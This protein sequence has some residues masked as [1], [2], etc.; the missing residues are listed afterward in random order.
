MSDTHGLHLQ[1]NFVVPEGDILIFAGDAGIDTKHDAEEF[2]Q[3]LASLPHPHKIVIYGNMDRYG[4][5]DGK[6]TCKLLKNGHVLCNSSVEVAGYRVFGSPYTPKFYGA[7][8]LD[9]PDVA[10]A[11]WSRALPPDSRVDIIVTHSPPHQY[12]DSARGRHVGDAALL[13]AVQSLLQPPKLWVVGHIHESHG[14]YSVP[15]PPSGRSITLVN[16]ALD[17]MKRKVPGIAPRVVELPAGTVQPLEGEDTG[18]HD[19]HSKGGGGVMSWLS[20]ML[21]V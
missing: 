20:N 3:W 2:D 18:G 15:H 13:E 7:Y 6:G 12:G 9:N 4:E 16:V 10:R 21:R 17:Y 19:G 14:V 1:P 5:S 8:Q 11:M